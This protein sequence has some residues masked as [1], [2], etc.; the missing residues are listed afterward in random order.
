MR[1]FREALTRVKTI[2]DPSRQGLVFM[3][4][5][6]TMGRAFYT[7][8]NLGHFGLGSTCYCHFTSPI[9]RYPDLVVHR[10]LRWLLRGKQGPMPHDAAGL[11]ILAAHASDQGAAAE[12][13]ERGTVDS[14]LVFAS[15]EPRWSGS[16]RALVN[17][18]S[19]G[20]VFMSLSGGVEARVGMSDIPGGPYSMDEFESMIFV[21]ERERADMSEEVSAKNWRELV[22]PDD[23]EVKL[24]R[25]RL[26]DRTTVEIA[27]RDYVD[28]KVAAK[29]LE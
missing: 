4:T 21:G 24:V 25:L 29:L 6:G 15:R 9:R 13:L 27:W 28:G 18:M 3:K 8:S 10:Q 17:G 20:G 16:Q 14:A 26:G 12:S 2:E 11:E 23:G 1:P 19:R 7:P 5:L 22:S